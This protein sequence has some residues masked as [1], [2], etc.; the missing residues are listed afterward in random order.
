MHS[1]IVQCQNIIQG[2]SIKKLS[3]G[4]RQNSS[5]LPGAIND[6]SK[7]QALEMAVYVEFLLA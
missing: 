3:A 6:D 2:H 5:S 4:P 1:I 7:F